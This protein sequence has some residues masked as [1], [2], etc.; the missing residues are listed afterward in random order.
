VTGHPFR[1]VNGSGA[2]RNATAKSNLER[3]RKDTPMQESGRKPRDLPN[4]K[5]TSDT[6][7][8]VAHHGG[9]AVHAAQAAEAAVLRDAAP[10]REPERVGER[11][12]LEGE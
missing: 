7:G 9:L 10:R 8:P 11:M 3:V 4:G 12:T 1:G 2:S 5:A 6:R